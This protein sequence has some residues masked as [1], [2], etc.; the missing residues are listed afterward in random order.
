LIDRSGR[1][2]KFRHANSLPSPLALS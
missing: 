2:G 1:Y